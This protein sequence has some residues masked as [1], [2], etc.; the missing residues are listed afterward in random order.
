MIQTCPNIET[1]K[2]ATGT[3]WQEVGVEALTILLIP[4]IWIVGLILSVFLAYV[5]IGALYVGRLLAYL[6]YALLLPVMSRLNLSQETQD[7]VYLGIHCVCCPLCSALTV[8]TL[9]R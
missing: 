4:C 9:W 5:V 2:E 8:S 7:K 1:V 3:D 6:V